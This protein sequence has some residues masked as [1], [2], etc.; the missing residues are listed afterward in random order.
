M[1]GVRRSLRDWCWWRNPKVES[2]TK[3]KSITF[4][5][6]RS[7]HTG[8]KDLSHALSLEMLPD[9]SLAAY[10][11][12][13]GRGAFPTKT[14]QAVIFSLAFLHRSVFISYS[15]ILFLLWN[16]SIGICV[17]LDY[18]LL[19]SEP[20]LLHLFVFFFKGLLRWLNYSICETLRRGRGSVIGKW[21]LYCY[22]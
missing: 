13:E 22:I 17:V 18:W 5:S 11:E 16:K 1:S 14:Q 21:C 10:D 12:K 20:Q 7:S 6:A 2:L 3:K 15:T 4:S 19:L 8:G 9:I